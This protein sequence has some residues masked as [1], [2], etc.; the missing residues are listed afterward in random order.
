MENIIQNFDEKYQVKSEIEHVLDKS[1]M[2]IG[3]TNNN[4][5][6]YPLFV[7]SKNKIVLLKNIG[8]NDGLLKLIDEVLSNAVDEHR[9]KESLFKITE[10]KVIANNNGHIT[11]IDNGGIPVQIH[12]G[13]GLLI[14]ELI[15]GHLRTSSNY[16]DSK[17]REVVGTNGLG[18]KLTN[19]FSKRFSVQTCDTKNSVNIEW[20]NNMRESNKDLDTYPQTGFLI[21]KEDSKDLNNHGT[22]IE[23]ELDLDRFDLE[24]LGVS[25]IRI[26]QRRCIDAAAANPGLTIKFESDIA[27]GKLDS[28]WMFNNFQEYVNLFLETKHFDNLLEYKN[29]KDDIVLIPEN[30]GFNIA[31]VNGGLCCEGTHIKKLEKQLTTSILEYC[32]KNDMELITEKDI[33][34]RI[35][36]FVNTTVI[37]PT[38]DSQTKERLTNKIDKYILNFSKEFLDS[39]KD[40]DLMQSLKDFYEIKYAETKRKEL[41][42]L[43]KLISTTKTK[44]LISSASKD[45]SM[46]ELFLFEGNS[47]SNGF[48]KHRNLFQS[49]YLLR[50]KIKNTFN[51]NRNQ[52]VENVELREVIAACGLLFGEPAKNVKNFKFNKLIIASDMDFDGS[53]ICGLLIAFFG[54]HFPEL[55]KALK[56]YRALSPIIIATKK[57]QDKKY[58]YSIEDFDKEAN[59]L[60][61]YE[62]IYTK[63]LGGL[64]NEDYRQM[65]RNQKL[66]LFSIDD[67][68]DIEAI[69]VWF[70][71]A[72][73]LRKELILEDSG[74]ISE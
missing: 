8:K 2:W 42:Q 12:K 64:D 59:T 45:P 29:K 43:N 31:F 39:L 7:P 15:F 69:S 26:L 61:G 23:F 13:T 51:L 55:F 24:D 73:T 41:K 18:A 60:K 52:I 17:E 65:L 6:E 37:N 21:K 10:I 72:T 62:I 68:S 49:A 16:D 25:T 20:K 66:I 28:T 19:I 38:Y 63:G 33:L 3:S 46:N 30:I 5:I 14:P 4:V 54:K 57:G 56:I 11:I 40:S 36:M 35:T 50:G 1:G 47:A 44:K 22:K 48:R 71:K 9:R 74:E 32:L 34:Q 27:E 58:Y 70:D 67:I 53:H